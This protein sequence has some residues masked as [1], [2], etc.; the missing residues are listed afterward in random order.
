MMMR[1]Q[2]SSGA[3]I[4][5]SKLHTTQKYWTCGLS[6]GH[7]LLLTSQIFCSIL[8]ILSG[9]LAEN[10]A[11]VKTLHLWV[12]LSICRNPE[13]IIYAHPVVEVGQIVILHGSLSSKYIQFSIFALIYIYRRFCNLFFLLP[14][15]SHC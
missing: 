5:T 14:F 8:N 10:G 9:F 7:L 6:C 2:T 4:R 1:R 12:L 11:R 3:A 15:Y 13:W